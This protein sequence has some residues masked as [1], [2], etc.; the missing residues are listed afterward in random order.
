MPAPNCTPWCSVFILDFHS[1]HVFGCPSLSH[2]SHPYKS[3]NQITGL[4]FGTEY[5]LALSFSLPLSVSPLQAGCSSEIQIRS[6]LPFAWPYFCTTRAPMR[7]RRPLTWCP[8][9]TTLRQ[10]TASPSPTPVSPSL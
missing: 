5:N 3:H 6:T 8:T 2:F 7:Q 10:L 4:L 9:W 1:A